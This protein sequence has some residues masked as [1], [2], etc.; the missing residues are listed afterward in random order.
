MVF[1]P[2]LLQ[3]PINKEST[4]TANICVTVKRFWSASRNTPDAIVPRLVPLIAYG[5]K[6]TRMLRMNIIATGES[7]SSRAIPKNA[8][9]RH[10]SNGT[11][12]T[13]N[14]C[15]K[16]IDGIELGTRFNLWRGKPY[17]QLSSVVFSS[18]QTSAA[19]AEK[20][21]NLMPTTKTTKISWK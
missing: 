13:A 19:N 14:G 2:C 18:G 6:P 8:N 11:V 12:A 10:P 16:G 7:T 1:P 4:I 21:A 17:G 3:I 20:H 5:A 15:W 9:E